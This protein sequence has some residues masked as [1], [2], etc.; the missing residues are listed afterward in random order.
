MGEIGQLAAGAYELATTGDFRAS[1]RCIA[2][3]EGLGEAEASAWVHALRAQRWHAEPEQGAMPAREAIASFLEQG[4]GAQAAAALACA[5]AARRCVLTHQ[6]VELEKWVE[7]ERRLAEAAGDTHA[8]GWLTVGEAWLDVARGASDRAEG[9][10]QD[11][12]TWASEHGIAPVVIESTVIRALCAES[13]GDT[14]EATNLARRAMR[15][16]RAEDLPQWQYLASLVLARIRRLNG[17]PHLTARILTPLLQVAPRH[18]H[19]WITWEAL[20]AGAFSVNEGVVL[21]DVNDP[22]Q[23][24]RTLRDFLDAAVAGDSPRF[25]GAAATLSAINAPWLSR[26]HDAKLALVAV[27]AGQELDDTPEPLRAWFVGQSTIPPGELEGLC[28]DL[29]SNP[30][31]PGPAACVVAG[32]GITAR[33]VAGVGEK[34]SDM[35]H[36]VGRVRGKAERTPKALAAMALAG[37]EGIARE[38]LFRSVYGFEF[39][40][41]LHRSLIHKLTQRARE[42]VEGFGEVR[43][44]PDN[45]FFLELTGAVLI[46]D[47]RCERSLDEL[48][49]QAIAPAGGQSAQ[50]AADGV[51]VPL[52]TA[53]AALKRLVES[54]ALVMEKQGRKVSY[55]VEDTT[56][57]EPTKWS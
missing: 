50:D 15:M 4:K 23:E 2:R 9:L 41:E 56:F 35:D 44:D 42:A 12:T 5:E 11:A 45:R 37:T 38:D 46:P 26:M 29:L 47:P 17:M 40:E 21:D 10:A 1:A 25:R 57:S 22:G 54:G 19:G 55:R 36:R 53:Q 33:R 43:L 24:V 48:M 16:A 51:G 34:V 52:R 30:S 3:L 6:P 49:L 20:M 31:D 8:L 39:R 28:L 27:D 7:L 32:P 18:W 14:D 13:R